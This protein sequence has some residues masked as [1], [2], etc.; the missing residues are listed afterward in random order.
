MPYGDLTDEEIQTQ[1]KIAETQA[2]IHNSLNKIKSIFETSF[3]AD[4]EMLNGIA[5]ALEDF[6][7]VL[8]S[9]TIQDALKV[10]SKAFQGVVTGGLKLLQDVMPS[11]IKYMTM[12]ATAISDLISGDFGGFGA[13]ARKNDCIFARKIRSDAC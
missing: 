6:G 1:A 10:L 5:K 4:P 11:I 9:D 3:F 12:F 8:H 2:K 13:V 7:A